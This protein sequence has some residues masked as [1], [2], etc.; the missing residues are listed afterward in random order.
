MKKTFNI[1]Y[2]GE[3]NRAEELLSRGHAKNK[4]FD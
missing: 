3:G 4:R 2:W 1:S